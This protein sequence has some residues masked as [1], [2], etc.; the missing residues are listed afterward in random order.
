MSARI[1]WSRWLVAAGLLGLLVGAL[2][3]L[4]GSLVILA[5]AALAALGAHLGRSRRRQ[6]ASWSLVLVTTG[7][8]AMWIAS[9]AGGFGPGTGRSPGWG[10][11][12]LLPY[13][14]GWLLG[15]AVAV[16]TLIELLTRRPQ[17]D[18]AAPG[19]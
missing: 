11:L 7:V 13:A 19:E 3:P 5:G 18:R 14:A 16:V 17:A 15:L 12:V 2:D 8:A 1:R 10:A 9:A 6:Y 4:E